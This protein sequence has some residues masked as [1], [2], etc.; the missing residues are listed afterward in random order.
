MGRFDDLSAV[1]RNAVR[2]LFGLG[3]TQAVIDALPN[4][5]WI[6]AAGA[7]VDW[8]M[9]V[10]LPEHIVV[11]RM[12]DQFGPDMS[13]YAIWAVLAWVKDW[14]RIARQKTQH[15]WSPY[16]V[17]RLKDLRVGILGAGSIGGYIAQQFVPLAREVLAL[18]RR[19]PDL[20]G[21]RGFTA[22]ESQTFYS[23]L[24][25][26]IMVLPHTSAT[27]HAVGWREISR[28]ARGGFL[29]NVGRGAVLDET[30]LLAAL[31]SGQ[32]S[33]AA[34][35]VVESEPLAPFSPLWDRPDIVLS[36]HISGPSRARGMV[37]VF[38]ENL[39]RYRHQD[40]LLGVVDRQRGY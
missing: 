10:S 32:L 5:A 37:E 17:R 14:Q 13:E 35:D 24:D 22:D 39:W 3:V 25:V 21:V 16:L 20:N 7:G 12:V 33:G 27:Y 19:R 26:L 23:E 9:P 8:L 29:V 15:D 6:Q 1:E 11:T 18:G 38:A 28:M 36:P 4:L 30:A 2:I 31:D 34:L 40:P